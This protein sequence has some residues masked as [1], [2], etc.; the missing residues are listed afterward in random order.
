MK[1]FRKILALALLLAVSLLTLALAQE[2]TEVFIDSNRNAAL[3]FKSQDSA[4]GVSG[5]FNV[6]GDIAKGLVAGTLDLKVPPEQAQ[7]IGDAQGAVYYTMTS[8]MEMV[9]SF[10][11]PIPADAGKD[12]SK[13]NLDIASVMSVKNAYAN[14]KF[15][16]EA[17]GNEEIPNMGFD[18]TARSDGQKVNGKL[19]FDVD[20]QAMGPIPMKGFE[21]SI[22]EKDGSTTLNLGVTVEANSPYA[23]NLKQMGQ[24]PDMIKQG[25]QQQLASAGIQVESVTVGEY[26]E[27]GG[28]A[29]GQLTIVMKEWRAL[30]KS[31]VGMMAG[32]QFDAQKMNAAV[33]K[34]LDARFE[35]VSFKYN[36][37][38]TALKG[39]VL[40]DIDNFSSFLLGYYELM[41]LITEAQIKDQGDSDD[42]GKRFV[43]AYQVVAME[44]AKLAIQAAIDSKMGFDLK[45]NLKLAGTGED[46]KVVSVKGDFNSSFTNYKAY[47]EKAKAAGLPAAENT[48][49]KMD[50]AISGGNRIKGSLFAYSDASFVNYYKSL[51]IKTAKK[52]GAPAE[53]VASAEKVDFKAAAGSLTISKDGIQG[54]SYLE[55]SDLTPLAKLALTAAFGQ[56]IGDLSGFSV[57]GKTEADKMN[58]DGSV[59]FSKFMQGKSADAIKK[60]LGASSVKEGASAEEVKLVAVSKPEVA[61]PASLK[62]VADAGQ[63]MLGSSAPVAAGGSSG[64]GSNNLM[65]ILGGLAAVGVVGV[66]MAA[67]RKK[68]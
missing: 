25:I 29:S 31:G 44:D 55:S 6:A 22:S 11:V 49:F 24:N 60:M 15:D 36:V 48:A 5:G 20:A 43:L 65:L 53:A 32:G 46:K 56:D 39:E 4:D 63:K 57:Q 33:S 45:G 58:V 64:G 12:L 13:L 16:V 67:G 40:G 50:A 7:Q 66:G 17:R 9:G 19:G 23:G 21:F 42:P 10:D 59:N 1:K 47:L 26:K 34:L 51:V 61:M 30:I 28:N 2:K 41:A 68:S 62:P 8:L 14:G 54:Q 18:L 37:V 52:A 35:K 27:E 38:G 3:K